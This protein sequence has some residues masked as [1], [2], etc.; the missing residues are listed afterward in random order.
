MSLTDYASLFLCTYRSHFILNH[1]K[2]HKVKS[3]I[4]IK[5]LFFLNIFIFYSSLN[6]TRIGI[7]R[8]IKYHTFDKSTVTVL[9]F[10]IIVLSKY[11]NALCIMLRLCFT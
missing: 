8:S 3:F 5:I 10:F 4:C 11:M 9:F 2:S 1:T 6:F 7:T